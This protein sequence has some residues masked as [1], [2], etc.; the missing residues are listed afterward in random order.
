MEIKIKKGKTAAHSPSSLEMLISTIDQQIANAPHPYATDGFEAF[1]GSQLSILKN[2]GR[3]YI[4]MQLNS[5]EFALPLK[6]AVEIGYFPK[7]TPLPS[8]P[9][10]ILGICNIRGDIVSVVDLKQVLKLKLK[11]NSPG[12]YLLM[13]KD[14]QFSTVIMADKI[15]GIFFEGDVDNQVQKNQTKNEPFSHFIKSTFVLNQH[16]I[17]LL[18]LE[19]LIPELAIGS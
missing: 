14:K 4:K 10:W 2:R 6:N 1:L 16:P 12:K 9:P 3:Q 13:I 11:D 17:H 5:I 15:A 18:N 8:L 19:V 7:I